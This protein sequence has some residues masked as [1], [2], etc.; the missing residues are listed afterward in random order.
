[1]ILLLLLFC[2]ALLPAHAAAAL[3][4]SDK[5]RMAA[6]TNAHATAALATATARNNPVP[7]I[8]SNQT[9]EEISPFFQ[10]GTDPRD[11]VQ[12]VVR[13]GIV[14]VRGSVGSQAQAQKLVQEYAHTAGVRQ[15]RNELTVR[16]NPDADLATKLRDTYSKDPTTHS[17]AIAVTVYHGIVFLSGTVSS[18][19]ERTHAEEL[20]QKLPG[21]TR[22]NNGLNAPPER[23]YPVRLT[24]GQRSYTRTR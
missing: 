23:N 1:M 21:V 2:F 6:Q 16:S 4:P 20:A 13:D 19:E 12:L 3:S 22:V 7:V 18:E 11:Q 9:N 15:L 24:S 17:G 8:R 14:T 10:V 5:G